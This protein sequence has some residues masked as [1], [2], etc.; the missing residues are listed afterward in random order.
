MAR[1]H[2]DRGIPTPVTPPMMSTLRGLGA[3]HGSVPTHTTAPE[4]RCPAGRPSLC[5]V[6]LLGGSPPR[7]PRP[8][9]GGPV[10]PRRA[11]AARFDRR[12]R[13]VRLLWRG[14]GGPRGLAGRRVPR[15]PNPPRCGGPPRGAAAPDPSPQQRRLGA[16]PSATPHRTKPH[17]HQAP[18]RDGPPRTPLLWRPPAKEGRSAGR[19]NARCCRLQRR[20][21]SR[22]HRGNPRERVTFGGPSAGHSPAG[23]RR[24]LPR[25]GEPT[26]TGS[27]WPAVPVRKRC[28]GAAARPA[29]RSGSPP[30]RP[31]RPPRLFSPLTPSRPTTTPGSSI[32]TQKH[33]MTQRLFRTATAAPQRT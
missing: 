32:E 4:R 33:T 27:P 15:R 20:K 17:G 10:G 25:G 29:A 26:P 8:A 12:V 3:F 22:G 5:L 6:A 11:G 31:A 16:G 28:G 2:G 23:I 1:A 14:A 24:G 19:T 9:R 30:G 7:A 13:I 21:M 18:R